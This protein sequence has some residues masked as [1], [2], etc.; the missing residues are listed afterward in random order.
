MVPVEPLGNGV[1]DPFGNFR[2]LL[3]EF[4]HHECMH[5]FYAPVIRIVE[6][7]YDEFFSRH[8]MASAGSLV[9]LISFTFH[10]GHI[11]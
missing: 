7:A 4:L 8:E 3:L 10:F 5:W 6:K 1:S 2:F 9:A 11:Q